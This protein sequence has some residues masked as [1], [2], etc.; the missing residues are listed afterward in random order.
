VVRYQLTPIQQT[1]KSYGLPDKQGPL[2]SRAATLLRY[3]P[4]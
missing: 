4:M 1:T 3:A 2:N